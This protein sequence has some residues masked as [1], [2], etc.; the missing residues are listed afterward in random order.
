MAAP[1]GEDR[2]AATDPTARLPVAAIVGLLGGLWAVVCTPWRWD[3]VAAWA[4]GEAVGHLWRAFQ[5]T[6]PDRVWA[7]LPDGDPRPLVDPIH[8]PVFALGFLGGPAFAWNFTA[9]VDT[10][11]AFVGGAILGGVVGGR[12]GALVGGAFLGSHPFLAGQQVF[13]LTEAGTVGWLAIAVAGAWSATPVGLVA[14]ALG[15][16]GWAASGPYAAIFGAIAAPFV[17]ASVEP[18]R[19]ARVVAAAAPAGLLAVALALRALDSGAFD[20]RLGPAGARL[21]WDPGWRVMPSGGTDLLPLWIGPGRVVDSGRSVYLGMLGVGLAALGA[22]RRD[23]RPSLAGAAAL[24]G[25]SLGVAL[26]IG[27]HRIAPLPWALFDD[28]PG[29][30]LL[31][32]TWRAVGPAAVLLV[33]AIA[34][35]AARLGARWSGPLAVLVVVDALVIGGNPWPRPTFDV[36]A[37]LSPP[38]EA[39][40]LIVP[41]ERPDEF[42]EGARQ[43]DAAWGVSLRRPVAGGSEGLAPII[44]QNR[45]AAAADAACGGPPPGPFADPAGLDATIREGAIRG[46]RQAGFDTVVAVDPSPGCVEQLTAWL[47][48]PATATSR[49]AAWALP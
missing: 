46:L 48:A 42:G 22:L 10:A 16:L 4:Q 43:R 3:G 11:M 5:A 8:L 37:P 39:G 30:G 41:V 28:L 45:F 15:A 25:L 23:V 26:R 21:A 7:M 2:R 44:G 19:R 29:I 33:P 38:G 13:G 32:H 27:G 9:G 14:V 1:G 24:V 36:S 6:H 20:D 40:V 17:L 47:G 34:A 35:A 12:N 31:H 18:D 49:A